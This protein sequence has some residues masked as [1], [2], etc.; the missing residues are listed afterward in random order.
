MYKYL[1]LLLCS[2]RC[3]T[4]VPRAIS[5]PPLFC[6]VPRRK[7]LPALPVPACLTSGQS[8]WL[9]CWRLTWSLSS[10]PGAELKQ[11]ET[12]RLLRHNLIFLALKAL[13]F[14]NF[15]FLEVPYTSNRVTIL[16]ES[17]EVNK[18]GNFC[19]CFILTF[20]FKYKTF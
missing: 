8:L 1:Y 18:I 12:A 17:D 19:H 16:L 6:G 13:F 5:S 9:S 14:N 15:N 4:G 7:L 10:L 3:C 20:M 11:R 2:S